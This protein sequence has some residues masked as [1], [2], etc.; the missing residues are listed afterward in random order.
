MRTFIYCLFMFFVLS[1]AVY[2]G[3]LKDA[4]DVHSS[5]PSSTFDGKQMQGVVGASFSARNKQLFN[6]QLFSVQAPTWDAGCG[7][8]DFFAGS[9]SIVTKDEIVQMARG[10]AAGAPGYF[11]NLAIDSV[12]STCGANMKELAARL[13]SWNQM[14]QNSCKGVWDKV[15]EETP[16]KNWS[17]SVKENVDGWW[18]EIAQTSGYFPDYGTFMTGKS[19]PGTAGDP[20]P[21][22]MSDEDYKEGVQANLVNNVFDNKDFKFNN[23]ID[24]GGLSPTELFMS[25]IGRVESTVD[26]VTG[27]PKKI[28]EP[29]SIDFKDLLFAGDFGFSDTIILNRCPTEAVTD[30]ALKCL[31]PVTETK[32]WEG[33]AMKYELIINHDDPIGLTPGILQNIHNNGYVTEDQQKWMATFPNNYAMW[34]KAC[35]FEA[36]NSIAQNLAHKVALEALEDVIDEINTKARASLSIIEFNTLTNPEDLHT[37]MDRA[38]QRVKTMKEE[39]AA[40][41]GMMMANL[42]LQIAISEC[43]K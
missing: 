6:R 10:I 42:S 33:V 18:P 17:Q 31:K 3:D 8:I 37:L 39:S 19:M 25:F 32:D 38:E 36:R 4:F 22:G 26:A 12:C 2:A 41:E 5:T 13:N 34:G 43:S 20:K 29:G 11:F 9:F 27:A 16:L 7:G 1:K 35:Y 40:R 23:T 28:L 21:E 30:P 14:A 15:V 24:L